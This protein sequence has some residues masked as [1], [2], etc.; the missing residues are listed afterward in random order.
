MRGRRRAASAA[1]WQES[2]KSR[3]REGR[4]LASFE[5]CL[6]RQSAAA[7]FVRQLL[8]PHLSTCP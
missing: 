1:F 4:A 7:I 8:G 2:D 6:V 3:E 5:H